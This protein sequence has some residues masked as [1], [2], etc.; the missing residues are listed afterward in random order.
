MQIQADIINTRVIRPEVTEVTAS[1]AAYLAG[2]A[3]GFWKT[4]EEIQNQWKEE[5]T[6][7]PQNKNN[8]GLIAGWQKAVKATKAWTE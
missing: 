6:F 8:E 1:G 2:L 7:T 5:R 3:V 4:I